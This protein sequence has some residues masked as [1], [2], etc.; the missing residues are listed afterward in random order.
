MNKLL[1][2]LLFFLLAFNIFFVNTSGVYAHEAYTFPVASDGQIDEA[3][4]NTVPLRFL[5]GNTFYFLIRIKENIERFF[6][7]SS[8]NKASFDQILAT[9]RIK[10]TYLLIGKNDK[11]RASKNLIAYSK[12]LDKMVGQLEK[13]RGQKQDVVKQ[14]MEIAEGLKNQETLL[15]A[16]HQK[17]DLAE[18]DFDFEQNYKKALE[19][20]TRAAL[21]LNEVAPGI[22]N[23]FKTATISA[24][25]KE[26]SP[27]PEPADNLFS[28][29]PS[30]QPRRIIY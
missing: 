10:E 18:D 2:C 25:V 17:W 8:V 13:A 19:S 15:L 3:L 23:R 1:V 27:S 21:A 28:A 29:S 26:A 11:K 5:P 9:K 30:A 7:P 4:Q 12:R 20:F 14:V 22:K 16:T 6:Q 24:S